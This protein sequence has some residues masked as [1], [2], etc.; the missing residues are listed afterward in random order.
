M[1]KPKGVDIEKIN[2]IPRHIRIEIATKVDKRV[3]EEIGEYHVSKNSD[4]QQICSEIGEEYGI[5]M[6]EAACLYFGWDVYK[7]T[8]GNV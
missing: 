3:K 6:T 4:Y 2:S 5:T 7:V 8:G 1:S